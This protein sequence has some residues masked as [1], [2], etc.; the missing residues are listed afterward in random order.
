MYMMIEVYS[1]SS[2]LSMEDLLVK[3]KIEAIISA[4]GK[5]SYMLVIVISEYA[6]DS[7]IL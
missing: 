6:C 7:D 4:N 3:M 1:G 5:P 2:K